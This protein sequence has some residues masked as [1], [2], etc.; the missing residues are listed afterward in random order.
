MKEIEVKILEVDPGALARKLGELG[1]ER[2]AEAELETLFFDYPD[3]SLEK[4]RNLLRLRRSGELSWLTYKGFVADPGAKVREEWEVKVSDF[5]ITR[6]MLEAIGFQP[7]EHIL[8]RRLTYRLDRA[9]LA[10]DRHQEEFARIPP[11]LEIEAPSVEEVQ[12]VARLLGYSPEQC[13][14][15]DFAELLA[16]YPEPER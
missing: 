7:R 11:L 14:A 15:W 5:E 2:V 9:T 3:G 16:H 13:R 4:G 10:I 1:A 6:K 12:A 8:K